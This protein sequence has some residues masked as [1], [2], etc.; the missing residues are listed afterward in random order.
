MKRELF[1]LK[2]FKLKD[3]QDVE[4]AYKYNG[5]NYDKVTFS[6]PVHPDLSKKFDLLEGVFTII[7]GI[8][9]DPET[10]G[11]KVSDI[12][13]RGIHIFD[14]ADNKSFMVHAVLEFQGG[15]KSNFNAPKYATPMYNELFVKDTNDLNM[16]AYLKD[17][18]NEVFELVSNNKSAQGKLFSNEEQG[19]ESEE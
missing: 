12:S 18:E 16:E 19:A 5:K 7:T 6:E 14:G 4:L 15:V 8:V 3:N 2:M 17:L 11:A 1:K 10:V 13:L 9:A